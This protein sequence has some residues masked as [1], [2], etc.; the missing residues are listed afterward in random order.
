MG[1]WGLFVVRGRVFF[2]FFLMGRFDLA[3]MDAEDTIASSWSYDLIVSSLGFRPDKP[4]GFDAVPMAWELPFSAK[5][6]T[7]RSLGT[8]VHSAGVGSASREQSL[9]SIKEIRQHRSEYFVLC[10]A[11]WLMPG[12]KVRGCDLK[13]LPRSKSRQ[14]R[15]QNCG[16]EGGCRWA[17]GRYDHQGADPI[18]ENFLL[19]MLWGKLVKSIRDQPRFGVY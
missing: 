12:L 18:I 13:V 3:D 5:I 1:F 9:N 10:Q 7:P 4:S 15:L 6:L 2:M 8:M 11:L 16:G 19:V 14:S 17:W